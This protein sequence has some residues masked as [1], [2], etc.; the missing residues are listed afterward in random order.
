MSTNIKILHRRKLLDRRYDKKDKLAG[1]GAQYYLTTKGIKEL[2]QVMDLND[3]VARSFYKN[4]S[5]SDAFVEHSLAIFKAYLAIRNQYPEQFTILTKTESADYD[6]FPE[7]KPDLFL[8]S[9][10]ASY[11]L[12]LYTDTQLFVIQKHIKQTIEH[13]N[14]GEWPGSFPSVLIA[15]PNP[16][17]E[18]KLQKH[19]EP[20][21][22]DFEF[23]TTTS[24]AL[25][26]EKPE[27]A[28]WSDPVEPEKLTIL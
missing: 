4:K 11:F 21:L 12:Y 13:E 24:K 19:L 23:Y 3:G 10:A 9:D 5:V 17:I 16:R 20:L 14:E 7:P 18:H 22:E 25:L 27:K 2:K 28:I 6:Q 8:Q 1:R 15:C 26:S